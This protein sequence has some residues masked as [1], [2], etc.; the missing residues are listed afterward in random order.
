MVQLAHI[1]DVHLAPLP[2]VGLHQLLNKRITG[3]LNWRLNRQ[4]HMQPETLDN[5]VDHMVRQ[6]PDFTAVTGDLVN[7]ALDKEMQ[8]AAEW[9]Q[10]LGPASKVCVIPGNHDTY[11]PG[12]RDKFCAAMGTYGRGASV[13]E[14]QF[15]FVRH[16]E[17]VAI[18]AC[19]SAVATPPFFANGVFDSAQAERLEQILASLGQSGMFRVVLIHHPPQHEFSKDR[20]RG[21]RGASKFRDV[22]ARTGAEL[23]LHGH[24]HAPP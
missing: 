1:S 9:V 2:S 24:L 11:L 12:S 5:L 22:I 3:F 10:Q 6:K 13:G 16:A 15:P 7:L 19:N 21:M 18:I 23:I 14:T 4:A 8:N 17:D 20:R